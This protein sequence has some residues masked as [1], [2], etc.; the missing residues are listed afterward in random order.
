MQRSFFY[1]WPQTQR[2]SKFLTNPSERP[3]LRQSCAEVGVGTRRLKR[4]DS[5]LRPEL[6]AQEGLDQRE[7][8]DKIKSGH[9]KE[10]L[11]DKA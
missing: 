3:S 4:L 10:A 9:L 11:S 2:I 7:E 5:L 6:S 1:P 8:T